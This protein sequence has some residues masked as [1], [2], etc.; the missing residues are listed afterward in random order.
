MAFSLGV[1]NSWPELLQQ[2]VSHV[3]TYCLLVRVGISVT[4]ELIIYP[5]SITMFSICQD[6]SSEL[7][8]HFSP[9]MVGLNP[10]VEH[11][12]SNTWFFELEDVGHGSSRT[13]FRTRYASCWA[14]QSERD[15][16]YNDDSKLFDE[17]FTSYSHGKM[18]EYVKVIDKR[19]GRKRLH[20][21]NRPSALN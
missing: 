17:H 13:W 2:S 21:S 3:S 7:F 16:I 12:T 11:R 10:A 14:Q 4:D 18:F 8:R 6:L 19:F 20:Y 9:L 5:L 15:T 1:Y